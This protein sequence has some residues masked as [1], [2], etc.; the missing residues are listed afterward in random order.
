MSSRSMIISKV[1]HCHLTIIK[2][3][4]VLLSHTLVIWHSPLG[5]LVEI[6]VNCH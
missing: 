5:H 2:F 6:E 1:A 4:R 3:D